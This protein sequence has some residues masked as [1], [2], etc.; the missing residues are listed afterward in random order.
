MIAFIT[1]DSA[2]TRNQIKYS[3]FSLVEFQTSF[4]RQWQQGT[5]NHLLAVKNSPDDVGQ[6]DIAYHNWGSIYCS[7]TLEPGKRGGGGS[8]EEGLGAEGLE[9]RV[10]ELI[11]R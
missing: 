4:H 1:G 5:I 9:T 7:L 10:F 11:L 2:W 3:W 6:D 8:G